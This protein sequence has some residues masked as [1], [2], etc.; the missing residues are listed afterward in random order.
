MERVKKLE[1]STE[2]SLGIEEAGMYEKCGSELERPYPSPK[3]KEKAYKLG[4]IV[5]LMGGSREEHSTDN[6]CARKR[7]LW[8]VPYFIHVCREGKSERMS[9]RLITSKEKVRQLQNKLYLTA[10]KM[11]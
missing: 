6:G 4:E 8:K 5:F 2:E 9:C 11:C 10:K 7:S 1:S 3:G